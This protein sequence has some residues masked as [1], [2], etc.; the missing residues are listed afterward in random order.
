MACVF[1][2]IVH[3]RLIGSA[4]SLCIHFVLV[5]F[6]LVTFFSPYRIGDDVGGAFSLGL[7][8]GSIFHAHSGFRNSPWGHKLVGIV[9]EVFF[10]VLLFDPHRL[11]H[12]RKKLLACILFDYRCVHGHQSLVDNLQHGADCLVQLI[13]V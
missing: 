8:G 11:F 2:Y 3:L 10:L 5:S 1:L 6:V 7:A 9:R 4:N 13:V 12:F